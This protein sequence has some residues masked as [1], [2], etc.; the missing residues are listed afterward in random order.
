MSHL[1][2]LTFAYCPTISCGI[3]SQWEFL[4]V[5]VGIE[6][7]VE[8][9]VEDYGLSVR[10]TVDLRGLA[11]EKLGVK[12]LKNA[13]LKDLVK[14]VLGKEIKK[15]KRVT[16]SRWDNPW[17]TPDQVQYACLDAF[18]SSEIGRSL[19]NLDTFQIIC[20]ACFL[21]AVMEMIIAVNHPCKTTL[22]RPMLCCVYRVL[23]F[24][25]SDDFVDGLEFE[26]CVCQRL[27]WMS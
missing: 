24:I 13:G 20:L 12:E 17:L 5:G 8:K 16:M 9:L 6:S 1:S 26:S 10:N 4:F 7:D 27:S 19:V 11:A 22:L 14:E 23:F 21:V 25:P 2:A 3:P 15:P 18:V